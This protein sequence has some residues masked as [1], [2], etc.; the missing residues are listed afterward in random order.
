MFY[1]YF[2]NSLKYN[3]YYVGSTNDLKKR[4]NEHNQGKSFYTR[5]Y[6]P[7]KLLYYEAYPSE[8][9]A[10]MRE[11]RL[12]QHGNAV[13]ELKKRL[14]LPST[15]FLKKR[16]GDRLYPAPKSGAGFTLIELLV[17]ITIIGI[18]ANIGLNTFTSS[19]I[20]GRD[21]KRKAHLRQV[22]DALEAYYNDKGQ[23][24]AADG[25]GNMLACGAEAEEACTWGSSSMQ[26][27]TTGTVYMIKM[28]AD[29]TLG[30][31]YYYDAIVESSLNT[32]FQLYAR[33][34]NTKDLDIPKDGQGNGQVYQDLNCGTKECNFGLSSTNILPATGR[35]LETEQ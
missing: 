1:V 4:F 5:R 25:S 8:K 29:P 21:A 30:L 16:N 34:E 12:K 33:L 35:T 14:G 7:W 31:S 20:K 24:P 6:K 28:P 17:S 9:L 10:R 18:L 22:V 11:K 3:Q 23:Y 2:L 32:K 13:R 19:Q 26:N 15:T 27:T